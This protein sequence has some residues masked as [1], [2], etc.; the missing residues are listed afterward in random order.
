M[1][2]TISSKFESQ[3]F[4]THF[5]WSVVLLFIQSRVEVL[6]LLL[7]FK[8]VVFQILLLKGQDNSAEQSG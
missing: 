6:I 3:A 4:Y 7:V 1:F 2:F 8:D 5:T